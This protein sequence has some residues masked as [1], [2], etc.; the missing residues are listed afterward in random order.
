MVQYDVEATVVGQNGVQ[1]VIDSTIH[2]MLHSVITVDAQPTSRA[3][4]FCNR[5]VPPMSGAASSAAFT[6]QA[7]ARAGRVTCVRCGMLRRPDLSERR[8]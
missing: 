2:P 3:A 1:V 7:C 6:C 8:P 5:A 4:T